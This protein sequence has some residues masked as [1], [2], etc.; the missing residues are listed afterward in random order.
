MLDSPA[1]VR[2]RI[3]VRMVEFGRFRFREVFR[4]AKLRETPIVPYS[5]PAHTGPS[6]S[7]HRESY[8]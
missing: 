1:C 5:F 2:G 8:L 7:V 4:E 6:Y 3:E